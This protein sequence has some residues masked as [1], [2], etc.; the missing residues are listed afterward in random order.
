MQIPALQRKIKG[1][2]QI[3]MQIIHMNLWKSWS[4]LPP[5]HPWSNSEAL[6]F[7][8]P[9]RTFDH[10]NSKIMTGCHCAVTVDKSKQAM[11]IF[12]IHRLC[13]SDIVY[14]QTNSL[15]SPTHI[16]RGRSLEH[17]LLRYDPLHQDRQV[18]LLRRHYF[19]NW[20]NPWMCM[21]CI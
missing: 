4:K 18:F 13:P 15:I 14:F 21:K 20:C 11:C 6:M 17:G 9:L 3:V 5:K 19:G 7:D 1:I 16:Q 10:H 12:A 8:K 2:P